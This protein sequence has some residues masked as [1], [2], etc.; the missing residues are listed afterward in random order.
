[1]VEKEVYADT[2]FYYEY[3]QSLPQTAHLREDL[4]QLSARSLLRCFS[5]QVLQVPPPSCDVETPLDC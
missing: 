4:F 3:Y 5:S 1:M 2:L